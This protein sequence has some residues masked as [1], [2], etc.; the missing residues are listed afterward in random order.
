MSQK[1]GPLHLSLTGVS[2]QLEYH[3][4]KVTEDLRNLKSEFFDAPNCVLHRPELR[5][6]TDSFT[7]L[8]DPIIR[9]R[10]NRRLLELLSLWKFSVYTVVIDKLQHLQRYTVR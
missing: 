5:C 9:E 1:R 10:F 4:S 6:A 2:F 8:R 7:C 3:D